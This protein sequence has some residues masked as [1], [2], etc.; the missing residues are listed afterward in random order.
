M[1][2]VLAT[3]TRHPNAKLMLSVC[4]QLVADV[5]KRCL[6]TLLICEKQKGRRLSSTCLYWLVVHCWCN[7]GVHCMNALA[8]NVWH[9]NEN[10]HIST[11]LSW[12]SA[13]L[14]RHDQYTS[15]RHVELTRHIGLFCAAEASLVLRILLISFRFLWYFDTRRFSRTLEFC[16]QVRADRCVLPPQ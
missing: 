11:I 16:W 8:G 6:E 1:A 10:S 3:D 7:K 13:N 9:W 4:R 14:S 12:V 2:V 5:I 15:G